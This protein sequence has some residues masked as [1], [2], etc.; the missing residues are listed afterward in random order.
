MKKTKYEHNVVED[1]LLRVIWKVVT[2]IDY[3]QISNSKTSFGQKYLSDLK[4]SKIIPLRIIKIKNNSILALFSFFLKQ[5]QRKILN[6]NFRFNRIK[7]NKI[8]NEH[9]KK[10]QK[11]R[12]ILNN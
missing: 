10:H 1:V 12:N 5:I 3:F 7:F 4:L 6:L 8:K 9:F 2:R 11:I